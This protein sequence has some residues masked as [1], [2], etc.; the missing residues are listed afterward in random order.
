MVQESRECRPELSGS[1]ANTPKLEATENN[2]EKVCLFDPLEWNRRTCQLFSHVATPRGDSAVLLV[3]PKY[4]DVNAVGIC[5]AEDIDIGA[6]WKRALTKLNTDPWARL[7]RYIGLTLVAVQRGNTMH[8]LNR[9]IS[10]VATENETK[11]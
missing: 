7:N 10:A 11:S 6:M 3:L 1:P 9:S 8:H 5:G 2:G 4:V